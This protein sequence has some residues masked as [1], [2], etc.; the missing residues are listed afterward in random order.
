LFIYKISEFA[1]IVDCSV[2]TLRYYD[3][4]GLL[5]PDE[6]DEFTGY[7]YYSD[8]NIKDYQ[9]ISLLKSVDF[10][11]TEIIEHKDNLSDEIL[12]SKMDEIQERIQLLNYK[13]KKITLL[14]EKIRIGK[15]EPENSQHSDN[16]KILI[17]RRKYEKRNVRKTA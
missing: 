6:V 12:K 1:N 5:T 14:R 13:H 9:L 7:R 10:T 16:K 3:E 8:N 2:K 4:I 17:L 15:L 11:L